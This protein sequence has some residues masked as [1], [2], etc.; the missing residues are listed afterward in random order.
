[1]SISVIS[2]AT[3][4]RVPY[5]NMYS[6]IISYFDPV[7]YFESGSDLTIFPEPNSWQSISNATSW[8]K[9]NMSIS[10]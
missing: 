8:E 3:L 6:T 9:R 1:M 5:V 7:N 2:S 4:K 10:L